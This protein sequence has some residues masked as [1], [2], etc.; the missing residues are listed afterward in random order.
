[1]IS[2]DVDHGSHGLLPRDD[3]AGRFLVIHPF[4]NLFVPEFALIGGVHAPHEM[5]LAP[6]EM[7]ALTEKSG[8]FPF[9][10]GSG[11]W[12]SWSGWYRLQCDALAMP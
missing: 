9:C 10:E 8:V 3:A 11:R 1:M 6:M 5:V 2:K 4:S 7:I 12:S